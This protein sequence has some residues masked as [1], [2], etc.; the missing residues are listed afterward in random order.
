M[1]NRF[2]VTRAAVGEGERLVL[3]TLEGALDAYT[4]PSFEAAVQ[5][6]LAAGRV[7]LVVDCQQLSYISSAG[8]GVFMEFIDEI[9]EKGGDIKLCGLVSKVRHVFELLG[10]PAMFDILP[11]VP[12]AVTQFSITPQKVV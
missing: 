7:Q 8:L 9:R 1:A 11:D 12:D 2:S 5:A 6:E 3:L 4:A 10:F